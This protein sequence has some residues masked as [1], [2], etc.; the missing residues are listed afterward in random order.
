MIT[1]MS[2]QHKLMAALAVVPLLFAR[3]W[4]LVVRRIDC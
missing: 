4:R 3:M 1:S 2:R